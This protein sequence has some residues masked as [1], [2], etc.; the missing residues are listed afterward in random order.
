MRINFP[1][2]YGIDGRL[3]GKKASRTY[4]FREF[5]VIDIPDV[6]SEQAPVSCVWSPG[7]ESRPHT[8][9][10]FWTN[11]G[12]SDNNG[13]QITRW[14]DGR[15]W[16]RILLAECAG[17]VYRQPGLPPLDQV[18]A[19]ETL[20][21]GC[22]QG[23]MGVFC[24]W[25]WT[26]RYED[27]AE[28]QS[29]RFDVVKKS[30]RQ[31]VLEKIETVPDRAIA[32]DGHLYRAC[33][34]P[35]ITVSRKFRPD[36][37]V[38]EI[39][40]ETDPCSLTRNRNLID[41]VF[42][43]TEFERA[44]ELAAQD[45]RDPAHRQYLENRRP[46]DILQEAFSF[47][48]EMLMNVTAKLDEALEFVRNDPFGYGNRFIREAIDAVDPDKRQEVIAKF[49]DF[50]GIAWRHKGLPV[51][52]LEEALDILDERTINTNIVTSPSVTTPRV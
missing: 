45:N 39:V 7:T 31:E 16:R 27:V 19:I 4:G 12:I 32:V 15:H 48:F 14:Y 33:F 9:R 49:F 50:E 18:L 35:Y 30:F 38:R 37:D 43:I 11:Q 34:E 29:A 5:T 3:P 52:L 22:A 51:H 41:K 20:M 24:D 10:P 40:V 26:Q 42:P 2:Y 21:Q 44:L 28:D 36:T 1:V 23:V 6:A 13:N 8:D 47:N 46:R 25:T 17:D